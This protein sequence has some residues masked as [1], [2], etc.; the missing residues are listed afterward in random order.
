LS[1]DRTHVE[2][3]VALALAVEDVEAL[4]RVWDQSAIYWWD[5]EAFWVRGALTQA[6]PWRLPGGG[7]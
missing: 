7:G 2:E 5:G 3:G 4:A 6:P 1:P